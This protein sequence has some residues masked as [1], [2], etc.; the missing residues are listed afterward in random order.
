MRTPP[1]V[2]LL[3][4]VAAVLFAGCTQ[5]Q[6]PQPTPTT[7]APVQTPAQPSASPVNTPLSQALVSENTIAIKNFAFNPQ[8]MTVTA[9]SIVRWENHDA[10]THRI[11]FIDKDGRD[12]S[13]DSTALSSSQAWSNKFNQPGTY[14]YYCKIHPE[15]TGTIIVE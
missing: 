7:T 10:A 13:V 2:S 15:M 4:I 8:T 12:T 3:L 14:S 6:Q 1:L 9:G 5:S 11:I